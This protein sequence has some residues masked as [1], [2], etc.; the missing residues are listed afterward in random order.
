MSRVL[1]V[2]NVTRGQ[3]LADRAR[4]ADRWWS[5]L[6]GLLGRG[7]L[8]AGEALLLV[9]CRAVHMFGMR[10]SV[11]VAFLDKRG[12]V[13]AIYHRLEPGARSK[14]HHQA[15]VAL[16]MPAGTL[17]NTGTQAGDTIEWQPVP[18]EAVEWRPLLEGL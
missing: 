12:G 16:E 6:R 7:P 3:R 17:A 4:L 5:R 8:G 15:A 18:V 1:S 11:D 13:V 9:P 2:T 14:W 10:F